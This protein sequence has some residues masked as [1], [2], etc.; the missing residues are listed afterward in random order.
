MRIY[1]TED[2]NSFAGGMSNSI[3]DLTD[4]ISY[5]EPFKD[6]PFNSVDLVKEAIAK[7]NTAREYLENAMTGIKEE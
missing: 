6:F 5:L 4:L 1:D 3:D 2:Y 7:L